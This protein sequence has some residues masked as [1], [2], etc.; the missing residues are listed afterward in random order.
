[1]ET[2]TA[3]S[4]VTIW[5]RNFVSIFLINAFLGFALSSTNTLVSTYAA[6]LGASAVLIGAL[7]GMFYA[8]A[9]AVRPVSGPV[10]TKLDKRKLVFLATA[11]GII[12]NLGY[13]L[14]GSLGLFIAFRVVNGVQFSL[15]G[16]LAMTIAGDSL[17]KEK[18][19]SGMGIYGAGGAVSMAIGPSIGIALRDFGIARGNEDLGFMLVFL[20]ATLCFVLSLIPCFIMRLPKVSKEKIATTG[21]WYK[22]ILAANAL[23]AAVVMMLITIGYNLYNTYLVPFADDKGIGSIGLFYTVFAVAAVLI[24]PLSG[25]MVDRHG[26]LIVTLIGCIFFGASFIIVGTSTTIVPILI[27]AAVGAVGYSSAQPAIMTMSIQ[28]VTP[29]KR[30]V[31][32]NTTFFGMD[33]GFF[34]GPF[35]GSF[36]YMLSGSYSTMFLT[37]LIPVADRRC[38]FSCLPGPAI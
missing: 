3:K 1:M 5:N 18:M 22:N 26:I 23:P 4:D 9:F 13:A 20:F 24:R 7:T 14:T 10:T 25:K 28:S 38:L 11:L 35:V 15:I 32:S 2:A 31:A 36:V 34:L 33:M 21:A 16:S 12:V 17:P 30:A 27:A 19:G 37:M 29:L 8:V 6:F